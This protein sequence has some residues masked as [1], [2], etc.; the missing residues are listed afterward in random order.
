MTSMAL[1]QWDYHYEQIV[2]DQLYNQNV[3]LV[4]DDNGA[5]IH[6]V[7]INYPRRPSS[8]ITPSLW[9]PEGAFE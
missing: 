4:F 3:N 5:L 6:N 9:L 7:A 8:I 1:E 2:E